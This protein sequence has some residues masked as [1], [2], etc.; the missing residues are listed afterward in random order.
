MTLFCTTYA[1]SIEVVQFN[2][3][4]DKKEFDE[5]VRNRPEAVVYQLLPEQVEFLR[6]II[7]EVPTIK[8]KIVKRFG[9][10]AL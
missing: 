7:R 8:G 1:Y 9:F 3:V 2:N 6:Q 10:F 5:I 4:R